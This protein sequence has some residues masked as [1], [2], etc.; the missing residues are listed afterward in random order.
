[1]DKT[2]EYIKELATNIRRNTKHALRYYVEF[3]NDKYSNLIDL[4]LQ[5]DSLA[6]QI[7]VSK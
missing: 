2:P 5:I 4:I 6:E 1:M 7:E 3:G